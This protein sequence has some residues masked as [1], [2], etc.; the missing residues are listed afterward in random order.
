MSS[1]SGY[2]TGTGQNIPSEPKKKSL[3]SCCDQHA[4][5]AL[6]ALIDKIITQASSHSDTCQKKHDTCCDSFQRIHLKCLTKMHHAALKPFGSV[7]THEAARLTTLTF[8]KKATNKW[9]ACYQAAES[10]MIKVLL[11]H[12]GDLQSCVL[13]S[14]GFHSLCLEGSRLVM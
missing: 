9:L 7:V 4:L 11:V 1:I 5:L 10:H 3:S 14:P 8:P 6:K 13:Y 2:A 12:E